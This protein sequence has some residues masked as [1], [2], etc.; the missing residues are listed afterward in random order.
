MAATHIATRKMGSH[1]TELVKIRASKITGKV[2]PTLR[3]PGMLMSSTFLNALYMK[4]E[5]AKEPQPR[6][7]R[8]LAMIPTIMPCAQSFLLALEHSPL[9]FLLTSTSRSTAI[10]IKQA[11][12]TI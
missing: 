7:S 6:V 5:G 8:K 1:S 9:W 2:S 10:P 12:N 11:A 3:V 4:V